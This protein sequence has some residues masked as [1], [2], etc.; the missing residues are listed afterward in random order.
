MGKV[1]FM[2]ARGRLY[3][4]EPAAPSHAWFRVLVELGDEQL[5]QELYD[6][7]IHWYDLACAR[8]SRLPN[9]PREI[10]ETFEQRARSQSDRAL[11]A[12]QLRAACGV[13]LGEPAQ[14]R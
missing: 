4:P 11:R 6:D 14:G 1:I 12:R 8:V 9:A 10:F 13:V 2:Q 3:A 7:A 5:E